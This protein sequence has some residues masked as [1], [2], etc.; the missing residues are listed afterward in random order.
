MPFDLTAPIPAKG[1]AVPIY[2]TFTGHTRMPFW[3]AI[4]NNSL[5]PK[6]RL[7]EDELELKVI[8]THR[9]SLRDVVVADAHCGLVKSNSL[10]LTWNDTPWTFTANIIQRN[11]LGQVLEFLARK[12]VPLS[13]RA[14]R[15]LSEIKR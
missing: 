3:W 1:V 10:I 6:L 9:K 5:N 7:F 2:A 14:A 8:K 15:L 4:S 11:W 13:P 12:Q